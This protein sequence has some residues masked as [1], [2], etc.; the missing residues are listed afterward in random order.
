MDQSTQLAGLLIFIS[1]CFVITLNVFVLRI[2]IK[3]KNKLLYAFCLFLLFLNTP[4]IP[5]GFGYLYWLITGKIIAYHIYI[6]LGT[7]GVPIAFL[8]WFYIYTTLLYPHWKKYVL[9]IIGIFS[10]ICYVYLFYYLFFDCYAFCNA[11]HVA[12]AYFYR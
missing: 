2:A 12:I 4:W 10:I 11:V 1:V 3:R 7:I 6:I 9:I 8:T 5:S